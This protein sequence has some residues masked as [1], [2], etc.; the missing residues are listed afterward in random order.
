MAVAHH[1]VATL[2]RWTLCLTPKPYV[3][4]GL[5]YRCDANADATAWSFL[6]LLFGTSTR[7]PV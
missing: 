5:D 1:Q 7:I 3:V 6:E 4:E 2:L